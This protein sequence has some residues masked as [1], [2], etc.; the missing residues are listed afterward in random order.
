METQNE[1]KAKEIAEK[2]V[3]NNHYSYF[4]DFKQC[5]LVAMEWKERQTLESVLAAIDELYNEHGVL[6]KAFVEKQVPSLD[7]L[8]E[9]RVK[10]RNNGFLSGLLVVKNIIKE[11]LKEEE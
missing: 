5:A 9:E 7:E 8:T 10:A 2:I 3:G 11:K 4:D 6:H 1:T